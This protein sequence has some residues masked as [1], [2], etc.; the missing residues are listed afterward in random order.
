MPATPLGK[1]LMALS[2]L[3]FGDNGIG[4][5][6]PSVVAGMIALAATFRIVRTTGESAR[7]A[8]FVI[9]ILAFDNLTFVHGRIGTLDML[10]LAPILVGSWLA[11]RGRWALAGV[12][13]AIG[14]LIK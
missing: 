10:V 3:V 11:M 14:L 8:V 4:W 6:A 9:G 12:A 13:V 7:M 1:V 5:R 2:M